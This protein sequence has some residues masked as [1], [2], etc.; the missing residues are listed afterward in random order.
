MN[1]NV[2]IYLPPSFVN[3]VPRHAALSTWSHHMPFGY[4]LVGALK[5]SLLV[6]LGT[7]SGLSF[8]CFCQSIQENG[9][10]GVCYAVDS[11]VGDKHTGEYGDQ[12]YRQVLHH[13]RQ[14]YAGFAY[15]M[16]MQFSEALAHFSD[17]SID[18][19]HID[20]LHTYEAVRED[21][22]TWFPKVKPGG[23]VLLHDIFSRLRDFGVWKFWQEQVNCFE[24]F[25]F[26]H[27]F[28]L[29]VLR[30]PGGEPSPEPLLDLL[31]NSDP[32]ESAKL[33]AYYLQVAQ[34]VTLKR[35]FMHQA[36]GA[37]ILPATETAAGSGNGLR[38]QEKEA[39]SRRA[40]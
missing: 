38:A 36:K 9:V 7:Y 22:E 32:A 35:R 14:H 25:E 4:D 24:H 28:G 26:K 1:K 37:P 11:W 29:G 5:P 40:A 13:C 19:L 2:S 6:E 20:G 39:A 31:F 23:I 21:F 30:K 33:R 18:L 15:L 34:H 27:G 16:R 3:F 12:I 17:E 8:F 10:D